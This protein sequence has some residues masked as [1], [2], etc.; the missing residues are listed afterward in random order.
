MNTYDFD[1]FGNPVRIT[2]NGQ[3]QAL[4]ADAVFLYSGEA[5][6]PALAQYYLIARHH[7]PSLGRFSSPDIHAGEASAPAR[8]ER[9]GYASQAPLDAADPC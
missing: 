8:L 7:N 5:Y 4:P 3:P 1:A 9:F 6:D 2:A